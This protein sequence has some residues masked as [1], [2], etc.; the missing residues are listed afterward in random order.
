MKNI[1][2]RTAKRTAMAAIAFGILSSTALTANAQGT[3]RGLLGFSGGAINIGADY[4]IKRD[5]MTGFGGYVF[6]QTDEKKN[7][8]VLV[9]QVL[10]LGAFA[11]VH[12]LN[13][14]KIDAYIAPGF[15]IAMIDDVGPANNDDETTFG[16]SLKIGVDCRVSPTVA[17]G[18][19]YSKFYNWL[20]DDAPT[21]SEH[22]S[23]SATF[24]F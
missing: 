10:A 14:S 8:T 3:L 18:V 16:P 19:Q 9:N 20:S 1:L 23:A 21:S 11:P 15:G 13:H 5:S 22:T 2:K 4:E 24:E 7:G 12:L 17:V 6:L